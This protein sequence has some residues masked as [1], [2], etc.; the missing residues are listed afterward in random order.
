[1][2][3]METTELQQDNTVQKG[4]PILTRRDLA[5]RWRCSTSYL[6]K[7]DKADLPPRCAI[8]QGQI[9]YRLSDVERFEAS[10]VDPNHPLTRA[11]QLSADDPEPPARRTGRP[12][13]AVVA[14]PGFPIR[15]PVTLDPGRRRRGRPPKPAVDERDS[16]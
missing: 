15:L 3:G 2:A 9:R 1:M 13:A 6:E 8:L 14:M 7:L 4:D 11:H 12:R 10:R 16:G 5:A